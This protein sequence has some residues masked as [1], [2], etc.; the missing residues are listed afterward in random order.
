MNEQKHQPYGVY[1]TQPRRYAGACSLY[2]EFVQRHHLF[3]Y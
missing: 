3:E 1:N 2:S